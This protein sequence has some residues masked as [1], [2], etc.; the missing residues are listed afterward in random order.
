[1]ETPVESTDAKVESETPEQ[2]ETQENGDVAAEAPRRNTRAERRIARLTARNAEL[3]ETLEKEREATQK[4]FSEIEDRLNSMSGPA[5][6]KREDFETEE[7]YEDALMQYG[8]KQY[9]PKPDTKPPAVDQGLVDQ[10]RVFVDETE[11]TSPGFANVVA[12]AHFPMTDYSLKEIIGM[13]EDGAEVFTH[14][15]QN[16]NEAARISRLSPREQTI[17]L[18]KIADSLDDKSSAPE[19][20]TPVS[21][22]DQPL[23][24]ENKLSDEDWIKNR[25]RKVFGF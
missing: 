15:G 13:G 14:L 16:P 7:G 5:R 2:S 4:K 12:N 19:P 11:K 22:N 6:P 18:E 8:V 23:V 17:E 10:F 21:G 25:N 1:M 9:G 24:D 3:L 20:I